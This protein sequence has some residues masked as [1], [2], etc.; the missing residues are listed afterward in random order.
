MPLVLKDDSSSVMFT[1][2]GLTDNN[3]VIKIFN[4]FSVGHSSPSGPWI[5][6]V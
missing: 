4:A 1:V 2:D 3:D 5:F 6:M